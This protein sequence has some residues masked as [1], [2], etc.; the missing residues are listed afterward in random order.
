MTM[1]IIYYSKMVYTVCSLCTCISLGRMNIGMQK[2]N[3][4]KS[5]TIVSNFDLS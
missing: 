4:H 5:K 3:V 1:V 2:T